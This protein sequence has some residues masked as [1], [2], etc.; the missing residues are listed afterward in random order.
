VHRDLLFF[1]I[2][3]SLKKLAHN[4]QRLLEAAISLHIFNAKHRRENSKIFFKQD[5]GSVAVALKDRFQI[6]GFFIRVVCIV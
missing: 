3:V 4:V 2:F 5:N 6:I 1:T